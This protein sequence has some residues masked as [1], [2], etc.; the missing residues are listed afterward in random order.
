MND[1]YTLLQTYFHEPG[2]LALQELSQPNRVFAYCMSMAAIKG[3]PVALFQYCEC[4]Q[5]LE[6][7]WNTLQRHPD[8]PLYGELQTYWVYFFTN[9]GVHCQR[10]YEN[11]K[12]TPK[13]L[14]LTL[15]RKSLKSLG[16]E[17]TEHEA[18]YLF[19]ASYKPTLTVAQSI[20]ESGGSF[21]GPGMTTEL[22]N[23]LP[24]EQKSIINAYHH[25]KGKVVTDTYSANGVCAAALSTS[26]R[27]I[28]R[29]LTIARENPTDFDK[30]TVSSLEYLIKY[31]TTGDE[32]DFKEHSKVWLKMN[33]PY[34]EY[35]YGF[36]EYYDD[37]M[38]HVGTF[39]ADVTV[40]SLNIDA[41]LQLLPTFEQR[42]SF[43]ENYKREDMEIL[44]NAATAHKVMGIGGSGPIL[45][46]IAYCLPNYD[47][48][49]SKFGSKQV[50]YTLPQPNEIQRYQNIYYNS[51]ERQLYNEYSPNLELED[52]IHSLTTTLHETIGH[53]SGR[54]DFYIDSEGNPQ[55]LTNEI[56][57]ERLGEWA[58]GLEEMRAEIIALYTAV[59]FYDEI[60]ASGILGEWPQKVPKEKMLELCILD[61]AGSGWKRWCL[62]PAGDTQITQAHCLADTGIMHYLMDHSGGVS[63]VEDLITVDE[64]FVPVLRFSVNSVNDILPVIEELAQIVQRFA[65]T[66]PI[67]E[68]N[69]FMKTYA[70]S[71][72]NPRYGGIV[73]N[74][75]KIYKRGIKGSLQ[76]FPEWDVVMESDRIVDAIPKRPTNSFSN[77]SNLYQ[78]TKS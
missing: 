29:A 77:L 24:P 74:M 27:W 46:T 66:A 69:T 28:D 21:Y 33:N 35:S 51:S 68:I 56:K 76:L 10:E 13:Q 23:T 17:L 44:P 31:L 26:L 3:Y 40:K 61:I 48:M 9:Y 1:R 42:F 45:S 36:I 32:T 58:N 41:L 5:I 38:S 75:E 65:S 19:D 53:A 71:T 18:Q 57:L 14:G 8:D 60:A 39:Q 72:R 64:E 54:S 49:R 34:V 22:Y 63:L 52:A 43:P 62:V 12:K 50:M 20:E 73:R 67:E 59:T 11:N 30:Y 70:A 37:P 78:L 4:S 47:D 2:F 55:E 25:L 16:V 15:T 6:K 7:I